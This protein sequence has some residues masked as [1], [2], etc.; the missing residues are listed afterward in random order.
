LIQGGPNAVFKTETYS[1]GN[2]TT[3]GVN[4]K[5]HF[6]NAEYARIDRGYMNGALCI[7]KQVANDVMTQLNIPHV[8]DTFLTTAIPYTIDGQT[9]LDYVLMKPTLMH[10]LELGALNKLLV[11]IGKITD[12]FSDIAGVVKF[13]IEEFKKL[14]EKDEIEK[15]AATSKFINFLESLNDESEHN[16]SSIKKHFRL[17]KNL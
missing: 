11:I 16:F 3:S 13:I 7:G 15:S 9:K 1:K 10:W 12:W 2:L 14:C 17:K 5:L 6:C 8:E 4:P